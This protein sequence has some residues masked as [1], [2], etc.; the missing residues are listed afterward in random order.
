MIAHSF[1]QIICK[2]NKSSPDAVS[3]ELGKGD[4]PLFFHSHH[5]L[6]QSPSLTCHSQ[7]S[8]V[9]ACPVISAGDWYGFLYGCPIHCPG[10]FL[11]K[12]GQPE[13]FDIRASE[14]S[15]YAT[16][17]GGRARPKP[18]ELGDLVP[19]SHPSKDFIWNKD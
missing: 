19:F 1:I 8:A 12:K 15:S 18:N 17:M 10:I 14:N 4:F 5:M 9:L 7:L 13:E 16:A 11:L 3:E 2:R 6:S